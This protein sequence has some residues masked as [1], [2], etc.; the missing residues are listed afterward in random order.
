MSL[1][2]PKINKFM[3]EKKDLNKSIPDN[4][5]L[6]NEIILLKQKKKAVILAHYYQN[7]EIQELADYLGDSL[8][9]AQC[10]KKVTS[11]IIVLA[12]VH[13]M[14]ETAKIINPKKK[15][16]VPDLKAGCSLS[17]SCPPDEFKKYIGN[18][19]DHNV[20]TYI[21][22]SAQ[23]KALSTIV[24]TSSNAKKVINSI[25]ENE[26]IIFA[27]DKNLGKYLI[28]ETGRDMK[29]WN[30]S[31]IVH[32]AFSLEKIINLI[33]K[34]PQAKFIAHPESESPV[35]EIANFIGSTSELLNFVQKDLSDT[36]IVATEN[37][38]LHE[39]KKKCPNKEFIPAPV[40][41][42]TCAC[43]ECSFMK[44][45]TLE[46]LYLCLLNESPE[47]ILPN[48]IIDKSIIPIEKMLALG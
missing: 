19:P 37:G 14:G 4:N 38:I 32:E 44:M 34:Y 46:K 17:D 9:L 2:K 26:K 48:E 12:G 16:L 20:V 29:L 1:I 35:L 40:D 31:C 42:D 10:A 41:D 43:S 30:G 45:N 33:K 21:N 18:H 22:C 28:K 3:S 47:I 11:D 7:S 27:P 25:P 6:I 23:I 36:F 24:C 15:V 13:F 8:Y 5:D 39:M